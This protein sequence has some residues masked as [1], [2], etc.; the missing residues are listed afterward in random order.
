MK[1]SRFIFNMFGENCYVAYD[2][3][4]RQAMVIDP[5][6]I[7]HV[8]C[9][10]IT[11][12]IDRNHLT[13]THLVNTHM[14][15]DHIFGDNF[16]KNRYGVKIECS[17]ADAAMGEN[18]AQMVSRFGIRAKIEPVVADVFLKTGDEIS[19]GDEKVKVIAV[20]GHSPGSIALY[21]P[22]SGVVF[23]GDA[24]FAGSIGRT[25]LEGGNHSQLIDSI[26][27]NLLTLPDDT[28][29]LP[30]HGGETT[31]AREKAANPF[32]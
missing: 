19:I 20:P 22:E 32:L 8:E 1:I 29:V 31:I 7:D 10:A 3:A 28:I 4:S 5:G 18:L 30:G 9:D 25:D 17:K 26:R 14:H 13:V 16:I 23:T 11:E 2:E 24:L 15:L 21:A 6:M 27:R 12:F